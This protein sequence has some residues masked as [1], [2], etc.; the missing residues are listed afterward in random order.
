M[1]ATVAG[2]LLIPTFQ[3]LF[4]HAVTAFCRYR[5][6]PGLLPR[7]MSPA[8]IAHV[9]TS[10]RVTASQ[11]S[12]VINGVA[13]TLTFV[14]VDPYLSVRTDDA[15]EGKVGDPYFRRSVVRLTGSRLAGTILAQVLLVPAALWI[16]VV[17]V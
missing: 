3:R 14:F 4:A 15:A 10:L 17:A 2:A 12:A 7:G 1:L 13:T 9:R 16:V 11:R 5:S 6:V 8:G